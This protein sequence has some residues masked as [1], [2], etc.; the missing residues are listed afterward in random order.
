MRAGRNAQDYHRQPEKIA[1]V[2]YANRMDNGDEA[3]GDGWRFRGRGVIQLT[4]R[5]NYTKFGE[6]LMIR[7]QQTITLFPYKTRFRVR[8]Y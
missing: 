7:G 5:H 2:V 3:S 1:N 8:L 4:G 6:L